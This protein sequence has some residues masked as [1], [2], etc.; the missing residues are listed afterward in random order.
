MLL[1]HDLNVLVTHIPKKSRSVCSNKSTRFYTFDNF[2]RATMHSYYGILINVKVSLELWFDNARLGSWSVHIAQTKWSFRNVASDID[3]VFLQG[4]IT[5]CKT[6]RILQVAMPV[7]AFFFAQNCWLLFLHEEL[8]PGAGILAYACTPQ[9]TPAH[10]FFWWLRSMSS[11]S[12]FFLWSN[13]R[14]K[15]NP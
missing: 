1:V 5:S 7:T 11:S 3:E 14:K 12:F 2:D 4:P 13:G 10:F 9:R 6:S 8:V 15:T